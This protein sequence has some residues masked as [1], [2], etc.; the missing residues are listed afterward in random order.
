MAVNSHWNK[1]IFLVCLFVFF[2]F[3]Y[4]FS[5]FF[6]FFFFLV[7]FSI[8]KHPRDWE[9]VDDSSVHWDFWRICHIDRHTG[10]L[11]ALGTISL[12]FLRWFTRPLVE[13]HNLPHNLHVGTSPLW[14]LMDS[15][16][17][18]LTARFNCWCLIRL[19]SN[20]ST[21]RWMVA[22]HQGLSESSFSHSS[23]GMEVFFKVSLRQSLK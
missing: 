13:R 10:V 3:F 4:L 11:V 15:N 20:F 9:Q 23:K 5:F 16:S 1:T 17:F 19:V 8:Y 12:C 22:L 6:F 21:D 14:M 2:V 7:F 18:F